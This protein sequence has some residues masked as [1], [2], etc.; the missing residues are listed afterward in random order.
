MRAIATATLY[1][2]GR[3][4]LAMIETMDETC[5]APLP[6]GMRVHRTILAGNL[7][8]TCGRC[9]YVCA[10]WDCACELA[11]DCEVS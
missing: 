1:N 11:H 7:V 9:G 2:L 8:A 10:Y 3:G 6:D 4:E 5:N